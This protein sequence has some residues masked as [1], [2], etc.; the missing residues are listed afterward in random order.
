VNAQFTAK[1]CC[2]NCGD[3]V[4]YNRH[5]VVLLASL[6]NAREISFQCGYCGYKW[7]ASEGERKN[8]TAEIER[9]STASE[10]AE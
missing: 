2:P 7:N 4:P 8:I 6:K 3:Q 5:T 10:K 9:R 1:T